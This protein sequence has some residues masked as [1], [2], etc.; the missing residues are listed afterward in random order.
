[1]F[2]GING[3]AAPQTGWF[4]L[5]WLYCKPYL[6][7]TLI[8]IESIN[9]ISCVHVLCFVESCICICAMYSHSLDLYEHTA[10]GINNY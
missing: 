7:A 10:K 2:L 9:N 4:M 5:D 6:V 3:S 1:M 8:E